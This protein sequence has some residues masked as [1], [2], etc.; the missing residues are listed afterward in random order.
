MANHTLNIDTTNLVGFTARLNRLAKND[1]PRVVA[2]TLNAAAMDVKKTTMPEQAGKDFESRT[3][4]FFKAN[5]RVEFANRSSS[6]NDMTSKVGF[7]EN[8][9]RGSDNHAVRDLEQQ[10]YG[11]KIGGKSFIPLDKG[12]ISKN[13]KRNVSKKNRITNVNNL[14]KAKRSKGKTKA[15]RFHQSI[16]FAG[17]G[18]YVLSEDG[19]VWRV[20]SLNKKGRNRLTP[21]YS[22]K[23]NRSVTVKKTGFMEKSSL[24]SGEKLNNF[25]IAEATKQIDFRYSKK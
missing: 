25:Y 6:V 5:S 16:K 21:L 19:I 24:K 17:V 4:T 13:Y 11:G 23:E 7:I 12:R 10:E 18:G 3:K 22:Y 20:D 8:R 15:Q 9:L 14:V 1:I 2:K